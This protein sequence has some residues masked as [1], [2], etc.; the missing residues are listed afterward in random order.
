MKLLLW[1]TVLAGS[2]TFACDLPEVVLRSRD[3]GELQQAVQTERCGTRYVEGVPDELFERIL[4]TS[5]ADAEWKAL[6]HYSKLVDAGASLELFR[7]CYSASAKQ[8]LLFYRRYM[9]GD[10][11]ALDRMLEALTYD[12]A[13]YERL[14]S[15]RVHQ[16]EQRYDEILTDISQQE[17]RLTGKQRE[18]HH[19]FL[20]NSQRQFERWRARYKGLKNASTVEQRHK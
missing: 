8:P 10:D 3:L 6:D 12:F 18:R 17:A 19:T 5:S 1:V 9:A 13:A 15:A 2:T 16:Y 20:K 4:N 14:T 7:S 11:T